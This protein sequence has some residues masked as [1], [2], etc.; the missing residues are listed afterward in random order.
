MS[1]RLSRPARREDREDAAAADLPASRIRPPRIL[2]LALPA[3]FFSLACIVYPGDFLRTGK[4]TSLFS[5]LTP[6]IVV[7]LCILRKDAVSLSHRP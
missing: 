6:G 3:T 4:L 1:A 7:F 2:S 5:L